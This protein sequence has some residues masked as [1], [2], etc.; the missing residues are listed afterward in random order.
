M[1]STSYCLTSPLFHLNWSSYSWDPVFFSIFLT[2]KIQGQGHGWGQSSKSQRV[3]HFLLTHIHFFP[4][5]SAIPL[6]GYSFFKIWPWK[7]K[8]KVIAQG[9]IVGPTSYRLTSVSFHVNWPIPEIQHF[10]IWPWKFNVKVMGEVKV[11]SYKVCHTSYRF[12]SLSFRVN[13][14]S[15]VYGIAAWIYYKIIEQALSDFSFCSDVIRMLS[16]SIGSVND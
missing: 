5:Q 11:Q 13:R 14:P 8:V 4:C 9:H 7:S 2:F 1:G 10:Q 3:S 16:I 15:N 12:T 6:Q